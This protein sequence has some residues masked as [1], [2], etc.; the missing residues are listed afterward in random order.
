M[1]NNYLSNAVG[2]VPYGTPENMLSAMSQK[3]L[4]NPAS[5]NDYRKKRLLEQILKLKELQNP[6]MSLAQR[7]GHGSAPQLAQGL[8]DE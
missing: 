8:Q 7:F 4:I 3:N 1:E 6:A 2:Q 5:F